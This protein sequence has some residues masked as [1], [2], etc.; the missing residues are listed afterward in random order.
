L[1]YIAKLLSEIRTEAGATQ[2]NREAWMALT[3]RTELVRAFKNNEVKGKSGTTLFPAIKSNA[4]HQ[5]H[6]PIPQLFAVGSSGR[7]SG[8]QFSNPTDRKVGKTGQ[9]SREIIANG[10]LQAMAG[11][12]DGEDGC[13][14]RSGFLASEVDPVF[15]I[16]Q[17]FA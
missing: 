3:Y 11:F 1:D 2:S 9:D 7:G 6:V 4:P 5:S 15:A 13:D 10:D 14:A 16:M 17:R 12:D 8:C